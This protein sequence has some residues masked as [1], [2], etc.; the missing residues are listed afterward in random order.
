MFLSHY[1]DLNCELLVE[2]WAPRYE[3]HRYPQISIGCVE[4]A[5][6]VANASMEDLGWLDD[7]H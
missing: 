1:P 3:D 7:E 4:F 2:G 5:R 6:K